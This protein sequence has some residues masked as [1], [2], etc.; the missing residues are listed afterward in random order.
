MSLEQQVTGTYNFRKDKETGYKRPTVE[1]VFAVPSAAGL[2]ELLT[3]GS[4]KVKD[5]IVEAAYAP[6]NSYIRSFV[7]ENPEFNQDTL[8]ALAAEGKL[9]LEALANLPKSERSVLT[10]VDLEAFAKDFITVMATAS[11]RTEKQLQMAAGLFI[12]RFK[13]VAGDT[14]VLQKLVG[15]LETFVTNAPEDVLETHER[16]VKYLM[17]KVAE[18][19]EKSE[20]VTADA[21]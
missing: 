3:N 6:L 9:T 18:L 20:V 5:F 4:E 1:V 13:Q 12:D 14:A 10:K 7:D 8:D 16:V 15:Y 19:T 21:L 11:D 17:D 2:I